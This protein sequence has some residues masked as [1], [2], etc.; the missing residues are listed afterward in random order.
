MNILVL[1]N[2]FD[3]AHGLPTK[4]KDYL[5][6]EKALKDYYHE[7]E[8]TQKQFEERSPSNDKYFQFFRTMFSDQEKRRYCQELYEITEHNLWIDHFLK[9]CDV[10]EKDTW[11]DFEKEILDCIQELDH[12]RKRFA[13]KTEFT[14][15]DLQELSVAEIEKLK[16]LLGNGLSD[17][18]RLSRNSIKNFREILFTDLNKLTRGLEIYLEL[19]L[20]YI[21]DSTVAIEFIKDL[22]IEKVL[23]FNYTDTYQKIYDTGITAKYDYIHGK[24]CLT[25][26]L[27]ECNMII[28]INEYLSDKERDEDNYFA[29]FKKFFQ[30]IY[31]QTGCQ[32]TE[33]LK[34]HTNNLERFRKSNPP[35]LN[36]YF[37]GHSLDITDKDVLFRLITEEHSKIYIYYYDR[38]NYKKQII[39]LIKIIGEDEL[40]KMTNAEN[41]KIEFIPI[42]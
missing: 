38:D 28:G 10:E 42:R 7:L 1:G 25:H 36:I 17:T 32:Y 19:Y 35:E 16:S 22:Q 24:A 21:Q 40:I 31:K 9:R 2:G 26:S 15:D 27:D 30:R 23:S 34:E 29:E 6:F 33:W 18:Q 11:I 39:N 3:L 4:Y 8:G 14:A 5:A 20:P 12:I 41:R 37:Y 13:A